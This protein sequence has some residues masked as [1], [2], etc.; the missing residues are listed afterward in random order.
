MPS[1]VSDD[2][3]WLRIVWKAWMLATSEEVLRAL[4]RG[5][6]VPLEKLDPEWVDRFGRKR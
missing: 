6:D 2:E 4:L 1:W 5:E 3:D